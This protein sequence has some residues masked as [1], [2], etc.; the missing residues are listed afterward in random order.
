MELTNQG[1][2]SPPLQ[3]N[4][5]DIRTS[6]FCLKALDHTIRQNIITAIED[7]EDNATAKLIAQ[8]LKLEQSVTTKHLNILSRAKLVYSQKN[9]SQ[10]MIYYLDETTLARA[11]K[12]ASVLSPRK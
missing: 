6:Y 5:E 1:K 3:L 4:Y 12:L 8:A 10:Q 11:I 7:L 2:V 9:E